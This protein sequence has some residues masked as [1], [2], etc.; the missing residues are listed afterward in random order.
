MDD[1]DIISSN[2]YD[3]YLITEYIS[4]ILMSIEFIYKI[5]TLSSCFQLSAFD[6]LQ[7][8]MMNEIENKK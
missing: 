7:L 2:Y 5:D 1:D 6:L 4:Y 8:E 3:I